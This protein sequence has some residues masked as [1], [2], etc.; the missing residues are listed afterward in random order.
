MKPRSLHPWLSS[1]KR[2]FIIFDAPNIEPPLPKS[3]SVKH[4]RI[5]QRAASNFNVEVS[6]CPTSISQ[7]N[8]SVRPTG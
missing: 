5:I 3:V 1:S 6:K 4:I 8:K 7:R 2:V